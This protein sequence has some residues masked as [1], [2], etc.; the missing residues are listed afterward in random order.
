MLQEG[1]TH[2]VAPLQQL[3]GRLCRIC[4]LLSVNTPSNIGPSSLAELN[5]ESIGS[6]ASKRANEQREN[7]AENWRN[8]TL[9]SG[10]FFSFQLRS[11][12]QI[13][14]HTHLSALCLCV[15]VCVSQPASGQTDT[16]L[17]FMTQ[18]GQRDTQT[19]ML[20][21]FAMFSHPTH[22]AIGLRLHN[23]A[24]RLTPRNVLNTAK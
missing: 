21:G 3:K 15:C 10:V 16:D 20:P 22:T 24:E 9:F 17:K 13:K 8:K 14:P 18:T 19:V 4:W 2:C 12:A 6:Q 23:T 5:E 1:L 7:K 11:R